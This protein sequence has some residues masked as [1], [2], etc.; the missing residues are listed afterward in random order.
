M[1]SKRIALAAAIAVIGLSI[2]SVPAQAIMMY[3]LLHADDEATLRIDGDVV[4]SVDAYHWQKTV[5]VEL[6]PGWHDISIS[7]SNGVGSNALGLRHYYEGLPGW[8]WVAR[9]EFRSLFDGEWIEGLQAD[10]YDY[11]GTYQF[12]VHG[13]GPIFHGYV[14][15][16]QH[17]TRYQ[18]VPGELWASYD[19]WDHFREYLSGQILVPESPIPEPGVLLLCGVGLAMGGFC[20]LRDRVRRS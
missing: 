6:T 7:F 15:G 12:T 4:I 3:Y 11:G 13:E 16:Y 1:H 8:Q 17:D 20:K 14:E 10:Y 19:S 5:A 9:E 18:G 2:C